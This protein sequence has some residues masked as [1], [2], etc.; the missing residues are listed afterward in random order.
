MV[1]ND[2]VN[3]ASIATDM[4]AQEVEQKNFKAEL[5]PQRNYLKPL[6]KEGAKVHQ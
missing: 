3:R 1:K 2:L 6:L 4:K 5:L